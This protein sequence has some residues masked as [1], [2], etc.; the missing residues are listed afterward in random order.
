[1]YVV[2]FAGNAFV[3]ENV[4]LVPIA[5]S[6]LYPSS[7]VALSVHVRL[8]LSDVLTPK[9]FV[10]AAGIGIGVGVGVD[11]GSV[12]GHVLTSDVPP[13]LNATNL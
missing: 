8:M 2:V 5:L 9:K 4:P 11:A 13:S 6:S 1:V 12:V 10:A 3:C 7:F